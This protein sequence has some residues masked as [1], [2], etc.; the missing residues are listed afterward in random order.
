MAETNHRTTRQQ[1]K[2]YWQTH[3]EACRRSG[4]SRIEYCSQHSLNVK[5]FAYWR[6]R[7]KTESVPL[8]LVQLSTSVQQPTTTLR[9][10][11]NG[12]GIEV[13]DGFNAATLAEVVCV[14]RG[15]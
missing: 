15:L 13:A 9:L 10:V 8:K 5:T 2:Q 1:K 11:V 12:C 14:L 4:L 6:H 7:L 3:D